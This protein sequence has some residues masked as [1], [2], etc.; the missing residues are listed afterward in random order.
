VGSD[1]S[2]STDATIV[3]GRKNAD[4]RSCNITIR[5][6]SQL[7]FIQ[8]Q[9]TRQKT[10]VSQVEQRKLGCRWSVLV[11]GEIQCLLRI[12]LLDRSPSSMQDDSGCCV[13]D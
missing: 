9:S 8:H 10:H 2:D 13:D 5:M 11:I 12:L 7:F 6:L 3:L 1:C 4:S